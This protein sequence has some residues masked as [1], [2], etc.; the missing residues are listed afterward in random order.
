MYSNRQ[1]NADSA[2]VIRLRQEGGAWLRA[3]REKAGL[4][5]R[6]LA[7]AV[8]LDYY[9]FISQIESGKGRIPTAQMKNWAEALKVSPRDF[10]IRMMRFYDPINYGLIF[11]DR[12]DAGSGDD[13]KVVDL[14]D[15]LARIEGLLSERR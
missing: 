10:A 5:Q 7:A 15:R 2:E 11:G 3:L 4:S 8:G 14:A 12:S 1:P 13:T 6:E 9:S